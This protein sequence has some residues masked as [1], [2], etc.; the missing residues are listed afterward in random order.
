MSASKKKPPPWLDTSE[1]QNDRTRV[2]R[3]PRCHHPVLR[4]L[5]GRVAALDI[6]ADPTPLDLHTE[7]AARLAGRQ[8]WC[9]AI[10]K[11][12]PPRLLNRGAEHIAGGLCTHIVVASHICTPHPPPPPDYF[13]GTVAQL[14]PQPDAL[15]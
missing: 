13:L 14:N 11:W 3:C 4:A 6:R 12:A 8:S 7:L 10:S 9:L 15:F 5:V 2:Q 1:P